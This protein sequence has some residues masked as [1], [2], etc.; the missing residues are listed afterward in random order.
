MSK[1][2]LHIVIHR[3]SIIALVV[4]SHVVGVHGVRAPL[5]TMLSQLLDLGLLD[6]TKLFFGEFPLDLFGM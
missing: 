3:M 2:R 5:R 4:V 1:S 6:A